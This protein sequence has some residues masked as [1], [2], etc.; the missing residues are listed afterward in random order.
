MQ[1]SAAS[2]GQLISINKNHVPLK[3]V[4][5]EIREQSGFNI[6]Y[7]PAAISDAAPVSLKVEGVTVDEALKQTLSGLPLTYELRNG[8]IVIR[9]KE[10]PS[11]L[12]RVIARFQAIDV[13]GRVVDSLGNGLAGATVSLKS[14]KGSTSTDAAGN[15]LL[16]NVDE[17][18]VLVVSYLGYV[19]REVAVSKEPVLVALKESKSKLDEV[20]IQAFGVTT[21]RFSTG[22]I[23][24]VK[25][26]EIARQPVA[27][28]ILALQGR[29]PGLMV[30]PASG[31]PEAAVTLQIR[32]QKSRSS[33]SMAYLMPTIYRESTPAGTMMRVYRRSILST[34]RILHLS[35]F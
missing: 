14:G 25:A 10:E 34:L 26:D 23:T 12:E 21:R 29:V 5:R 9:K 18:A 17:G 31:L 35:T 3:E 27:N 13:K 28:P 24:S 11:F 8:N 2:Y 6:Y 19:T 7:D 20:Q 33:S 15:F 16:K 32:G 4:L 1:V 30:T 22:D